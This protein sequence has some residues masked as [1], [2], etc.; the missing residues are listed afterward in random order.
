MH[1][2]GNG[3]DVEGAFDIQLV[4]GLWKLIIHGAEVSA[5]GGV[6]GAV[7]L[8]K[9][10][11]G[12][13]CRKADVIEERLLRSGDMRHFVKRHAEFVMRAAAIDR[14]IAGAHAHHVGEGGGGQQKSG[15]Q[16]VKAG[17]AVHGASCGSSMGCRALSNRRYRMRISAS[18]G[19]ERKVPGTPPISAPAKTP[20]MTSN[21]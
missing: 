16:A 18:S 17:D 20:N 19:T 21:G 7:F 9:L 1:V 15:Q 14:E 5:L 8:D 13:T 10:C 2:V 4:Y 12:A 6:R 11:A 3:D